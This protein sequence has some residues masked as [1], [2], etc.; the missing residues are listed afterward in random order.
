MAVGVGHA[1]STVRFSVRRSL[2]YVLLA[3]SMPAVGVIGWLMADAYR[4]QSQA[5]ENTAEQT[6]QQ[7]MT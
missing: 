7:A 5:M 3:C 4:L 1:V 6:A 2:L